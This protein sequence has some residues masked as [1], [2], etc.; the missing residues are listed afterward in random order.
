MA[1]GQICPGYMSGEMFSVVQVR[2]AMQ[3]NNFLIHHTPFDSYHD[4]KT[5]SL[6]LY[7]RTPDEALDRHLCS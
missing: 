1:I 4:S 3:D 5:M 6:F 7:I 2:I